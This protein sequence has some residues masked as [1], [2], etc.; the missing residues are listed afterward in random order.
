[1]RE[2]PLIS[3]IIIAYNRKKFLSTAIFSALNQTLDKSKYEIIVVKNF[4]DEEIDALIEKAGVT[5]LQRG[6]EIVGSYIAAGVEKSRG[7]ILVFLDDDDEFVKGKLQVIDE[8]FASDQGVG[9]YHND[10]ILVDSSGQQISTNFRKGSSDFIEK[11]GRFRLEKPMTGGHANKLLRASAYGYLS[12]IAIRKSV[13]APFLRDL[14]QSVESAQDIFV[15]YC[16]LLSSSCRILVVDPL[17]LTRYRL[18]AANV[19]VFADA[20]KKNLNTER[21]I[22][23][24]QFLERE[25]KSMETILKIATETQYNRDKRNLKVVEKMI[26]YELYS[27]KVDLNMVDPSSTRGRVLSDALRFFKYSFRSRFVSN[28][29]T[30]LVRCLLWVAFPKVTKRAFVRRFGS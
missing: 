30:I 19:S 7:E 23:I 27:R 13:M 4:K 21:E 28:Q 3:V 14:T 29:V 25:K 12:S 15:F 8:I 17:K 16:A 26:G 24:L 20:G 9:Y 2:S 10:I 1:M 11:A 18:H 22:Q 6:D 5:S